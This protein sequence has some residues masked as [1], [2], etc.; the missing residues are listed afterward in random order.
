MFRV[1]GGFQR[2]Y[3]SNFAN[4]RTVDVFCLLKTKLIL[5]RLLSATAT[6]TKLFVPIANS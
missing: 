2:H 4:F 1:S 3:M 5:Y 6:A